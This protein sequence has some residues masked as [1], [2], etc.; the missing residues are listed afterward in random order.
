MMNESQTS[1][2]AEYQQ[3]GSDELYKA[4]S[5]DVAA[6][7]STKNFTFALQFHTRPPHILVS[8]FRP[9]SSCWITLRPV[10]VQSVLMWKF[11]LL[12]IK[13]H[14]FIIVS[15]PFVLKFVIIITWNSKVA[16]QNGSREW[17]RVTPDKIPPQ[18]IWRFRRVGW[19]DKAKT[20]KL[21]DPVG[22]WKRSSY[23]VSSQSLASYVITMAPSS[24]DGVFFFP[25]SLCLRA[26]LTTCL[27]KSDADNS[28]WHRTRSS[29]VKLS[30]AER[31]MILL[32]AKKQIPRLRL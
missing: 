23:N 10:F 26:G 25:P 29:H 30:D 11:Q 15:W 28:L 21:L 4:L 22:F 19:K 12:A 1:A 9:D 20:K 6:A 16:T 5:V 8:F 7:A 13:S 2:G 27:R 24:R 17:R 32:G 18:V 31:L 14:H 3:K